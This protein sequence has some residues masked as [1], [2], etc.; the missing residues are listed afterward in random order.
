MGIAMGIDAHSGTPT[1]HPRAHTPAST[2]S[3]AST[4]T[5]AT[6]PTGLLSPLHVPL[7]TSPFGEQRLRPS[8]VFFRRGMAVTVP[9]PAPA[10]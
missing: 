7:K 2:A 9:A 1:P 4:A 8:T 6:A 5:T 10:R 3:T